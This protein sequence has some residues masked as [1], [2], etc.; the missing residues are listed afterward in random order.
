MRKIPGVLENFIMK[1]L[2]NSARCKKCKDEIQSVH[3][4]DFKWCKCG[5]IFVDGGNSY[6]R[7]GGDLDLFESTALTDEEVDKPP[8]P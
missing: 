1:I 2:R 4:H 7:G 5:A 6:L 8:T 3:R